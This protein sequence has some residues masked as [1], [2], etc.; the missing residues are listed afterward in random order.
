MD[1][2]YCL[3][4]PVMSS[5]S[6]SRFIKWPHM[7][8]SR[9]SRRPENTNIAHGLDSNAMSSYRSLDAH[10]RLVLEAKTLSN[11]RPRFEFKGAFKDRVTDSS[12]V[13]LTA[14]TSATIIAA[15]MISP[16]TLPSRL[17]S[18]PFIMDS[19]AAAGTGLKGHK[20]EG[21]GEGKVN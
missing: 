7:G 3:H 15:P 21:R 14:T 16:T 13:A 19:S 20:G 8:P 18:I 12:L 6:T 17:P 9:K 11:L 1:G 4:L 5:I 10:L 2:G